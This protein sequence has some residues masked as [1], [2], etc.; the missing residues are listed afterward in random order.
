M[1]RLSAL[2]IM[3]IHR[4]RSVDYSEAVKLFMELHPRKI[5]LKNLVYKWDVGKLVILYFLIVNICFCPHVQ[6]YLNME[7]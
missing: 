1:E 6:F 7:M 3:H 4:D 5:E 2:A